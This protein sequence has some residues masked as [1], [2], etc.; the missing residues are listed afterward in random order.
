M[1]LLMPGGSWLFTFD[2]MR[3]VDL[4]PDWAAAAFLLGRTILREPR[5]RVVAFL[6]GWAI[7]AGVALIPGVGGLI[8][9]AGTVFG[10]GT[11]VVAIWRARGAP[12]S[13]TVAVPIPIPPPPATGS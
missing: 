1:A 3:A 10:L 11:I 9:F 5:G 12:R 7:L 13:G 2:A 4:T 8:W 6:A